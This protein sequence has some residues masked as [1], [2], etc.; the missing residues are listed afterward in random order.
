MGDGS[1]IEFVSSSWCQMWFFAS[2]FPWKAGFKHSF[3]TLKLPLTAGVISTSNTIIHNSLCWLVKCLREGKRDIF[4][5]KAEKDRGL[6]TL[7]LS[8]PGPPPIPPHPARPHFPSGKSAVL[9]WCCSSWICPCWLSRRAALSCWGGA[10]VS[11]RGGGRGWLC[12]QAGVCSRMPEPR[13][14]RRCGCSSL[15]WRPSTPGT[16]LLPAVWP[17]MN[18]DGNI[19]SAQN[20]LVFYTSRHIN[21]DGCCAAASSQSQASFHPSVSGSLSTLG[22]QQVI[23]KAAAFLIK[24]KSV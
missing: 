7:L 6:S 12:W 23:S 21:K 15:T 4:W 10:G 3:Y 1:S 13:Y 19:N 9:T 17:G 2:T 16:L 20:Q 18:P 8:Q 22:S 5:K 11:W 14:G 24:K